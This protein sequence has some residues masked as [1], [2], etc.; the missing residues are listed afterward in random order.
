[1][2]RLVG[3][4]D[5]ERTVTVWS[6]WSRERWVIE[7][8]Y[9]LRYVEDVLKIGHEPILVGRREH[10]WFEAGVD[11]NDPDQTTKETEPASSTLFPA[12]AYQRPRGRR[13]V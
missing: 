13:L 1:M 10:A 6:R 5:A 12:V 7:R 9:P 3:G 8:S 2:T 4:D 11:P